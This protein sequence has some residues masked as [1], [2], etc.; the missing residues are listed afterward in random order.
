MLQFSKAVG[1]NP[2]DSA[3]VIE[4]CVGGLL[5]VV[6][7]ND[8]AQTL[9]IGLFGTDALFRVGFLAFKPRPASGSL[10]YPL[11]RIWEGR[12]FCHGF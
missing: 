2:A 7:K 8:E 6:L 3:S 11:G 1:T 12:W 10:S 9:V 4:I 5:A